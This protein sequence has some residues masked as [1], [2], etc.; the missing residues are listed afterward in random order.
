M[1]IMYNS[2]SLISP[3]RFKLL[4]NSSSVNFCC[5]RKLLMPSNSIKKSSFIY[6]L[7]LIDFELLQQKQANLTATT[8]NKNKRPSNVSNNNVNGNN[9]NQLIENLFEEAIFSSELKLDEKKTIGKKYFDYLLSISSPNFRKIQYQIANL[10][11]K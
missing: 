8:T 9:N 1:S 10:S 2:F 11:S 5:L 3:T 7:T 6:W 4:F